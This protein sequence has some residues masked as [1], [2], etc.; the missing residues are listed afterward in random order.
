MRKIYERH[1]FKGYRRITRDL[2]DMDYVVN[3][4]KFIS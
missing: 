2:Q 3:H 1:S 4:K